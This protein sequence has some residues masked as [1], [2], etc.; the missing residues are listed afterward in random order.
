M[1]DRTV[2]SGVRK[3]ELYHWTIVARRTTGSG[4]LLEPLGFFVIP[5]ASPTTAQVRVQTVE[6]AWQYYQQEKQWSFRH[7]IAVDFMSLKTGSCGNAKLEVHWPVE[8]SQEQRQFSQNKI[9]QECV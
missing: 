7:S 9:C 3:P 8:Y 5:P 6:R 4:C 2:D 1:G